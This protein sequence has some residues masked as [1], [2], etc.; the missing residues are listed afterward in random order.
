MERLRAPQPLAT[1]HL[2]P[3][4]SLAGRQPPVT[5][6]DPPAAVR[7]PSTDSPY[8]R[9]AARRLLRVEGVHTGGIA[10]YF[11]KMRSRALFY[12]PHKKERTP[13]ILNIIY[14]MYFN[15]FESLNSDAMPLEMHPFS[16]PAYTAV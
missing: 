7:P 16:F 3:P 9:R 14:K 12:T 4:A 13:S 15:K 10:E 2:T 6:G 5:S 1:E 11:P 8:P